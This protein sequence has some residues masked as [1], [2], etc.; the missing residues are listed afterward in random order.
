MTLGLDIEQFREFIVTPALEQIGLY[1]KAAE[2]LV[3][4]T[5]LVESGL[6]YV[7]Q[8]GGGPALGFFQME[9]RTHDDIW[10]SYLRY[11]T[12]LAGRLRTLT[13][14]GL[15]LHSQLVGNHYYAAAMCRVHY[16]RVPSALPAA[17]DLEG[18]AKYWKDHYNTRL[19]KG[20]IEG[21]I[22]KA[23]GVL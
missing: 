6:R 13:V 20:T 21:F 1:S 18:Q 9:P 5:A 8:L 14:E 7:R 11:K 23:G 22:K 17:D 15:D 2:T 16:L 4:R 12:D 10:Q 3:T 19:G